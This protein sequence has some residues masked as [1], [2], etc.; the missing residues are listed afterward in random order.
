MKK[1]QHKTKSTVKKFNLFGV[2]FSAGIADGW[3]L[4]RLKAVNGGWM[5]FTQDINFYKD[6]EEKS[7]I[8]TYRLILWKIKL[9]MKML[10]ERN[11]VY[12]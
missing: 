7:G 1:I 9:E 8:I 3:Q 11:F 2:N 12:A 6:K 10:V 5:T 4:S